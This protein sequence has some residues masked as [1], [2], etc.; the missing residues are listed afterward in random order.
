MQRLQ[1]SYSFPQYIMYFSIYI[2]KCIYLSDPIVFGVNPGLLMCP[3][4]VTVCVCV[5]VCVYNNNDFDN[6]SFILAQA[7]ADSPFSGACQIF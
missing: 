7:S 1:E 2:Y 6:T 4:C 5:C 3:I